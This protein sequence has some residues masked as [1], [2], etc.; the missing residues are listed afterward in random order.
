HAVSTKNDMAQKYFDQGLRLTFGFNHDEAERAFRE[1]ARL[2]PNLAMAWWGVANALGPNI[3]L[4]L[5]DERNK[6]ALDAVAKAKSLI[7]NASD[8]ERAS[9]GSIGSRYSSDQT[10]MR[11]EVDHAVGEAFG[12]GYYRFRNDADAG[13]LNA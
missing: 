7:A 3:N 6:R 11:L 5:D 10:A 13:A 4:P 2:D 1:A 9:I 12:E 8:S